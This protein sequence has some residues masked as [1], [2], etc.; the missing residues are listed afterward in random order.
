[1][2]KLEE[3][4]YVEQPQRYVMKEKEE[5]VYKLKNLI[6][7]EIDNKSIMHMYWYLF[8]NKHISKMSLSTH[9]LYV[10][11]NFMSNIIFVCLYMNDLII[12]DDT[13]KM[14]IEFKKVM[15]GRFDMIDWYSILLGLK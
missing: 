11:S 7:I 8:Y 2:A 12:I 10:K 14:I 15:I 3:E 13:L 5:L 9:I 4:V 1:M 6:L